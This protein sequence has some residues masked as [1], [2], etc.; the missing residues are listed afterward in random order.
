MSQVEEGEYR[1][2]YVCILAYVRFACVIPIDTAADDAPLLLHCAGA[3][4]IQRKRGLESSSSSCC[5]MA[6]PQK[7]T[8][9]QQ[10][11]IAVYSTVRNCAKKG[12]L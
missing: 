10:Q 11:Y 9:A 7:H 4:E 12:R 1:R 2:S 3:F 5:R 6:R 8:L